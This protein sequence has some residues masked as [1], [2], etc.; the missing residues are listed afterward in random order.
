MTLEN[1]L[2]SEQERKE[3]KE[4]QEENYRIANEIFDEMAKPVVLAFN[5]IITAIINDDYDLIKNKL[6]N[7]GYEPR[8]LDKVYNSV[9]NWFSHQANKIKRVFVRPN[10][11]DLLNNVE[12]S[13]KKLPQNEREPALDMFR[14]VTEKYVSMLIN[15]G[16]QR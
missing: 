12:T 13:F 4:H 10:I 15:G 11:S 5:S 16:A 7:K 9:F 1:G 2:F 8:K 14:E 3:I 6:I